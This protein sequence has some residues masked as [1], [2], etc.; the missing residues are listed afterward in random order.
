MS[1]PNIDH[2]LKEWD[3]A[4]RAGEIGKDCPDLSVLL[5]HVTEGRDLAEHHSHV[6]DC[7]RCQKRLDLIH[8]ELAQA[9]RL[10]VLGVPVRRSM[11]WAGGA[12][13][14]AASIALVVVLLPEPTIDAQVAVF[15]RFGYAWADD[16]TMRGEGTSP[17]Q[18]NDMTAGIPDWVAQVLSD[19]Q[20]QAAID[21][22]KGDWAKVM[23]GLRAVQP[24]RLM[25]DQDGGLTIAPHIDKD[26]DLG[27]Q[28]DVLVTRDRQ[29]TERI[30]DAIIRLVPR[31]SEENRPAI[32]TALDSWRAKNLFGQSVKG[33]E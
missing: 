22:Q 14:L 9:G 33:K 20:V 15:A 4:E 18:L 21:K 27:Q 2:L 7:P 24:P 23:H 3:E 1:E 19:E 32:R 8:G 10:R 13:A 31:A 28:L 6:T 25:F 26:S 12:L 16:A 17:S 5:S 11:A 30:V 29:T